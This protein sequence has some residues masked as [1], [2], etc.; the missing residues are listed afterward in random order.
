MRSFSPFHDSM[1]I[2][3]RLCG[4]PQTGDIRYIAVSYFSNSLQA[5]VSPLTNIVKISTLCSRVN[6]IFRRSFITVISA[7][8]RIRLKNNQM[9]CFGLSSLSSHVSNNN[10]TVIS[11]HTVV[12]STCNGVFNST[13]K[14]QTGYT[15]TWM[16]WIIQ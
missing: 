12:F 10:Q 13:G 11:V 9:L 15:L 2:R 14:L 16:N 1:G 4:T 7:G 8:G 3:A 6:S 5:F